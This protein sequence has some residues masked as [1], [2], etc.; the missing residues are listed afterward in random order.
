MNPKFKELLE[1]VGGHGTRALMHPDDVEKFA[2]LIV[3]DAI[4]IAESQRGPSTL[5]YSPGRRCAEDLRY[6]FGVK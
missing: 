1:Q 4:K 6:H 2:E 5:N 3:Q